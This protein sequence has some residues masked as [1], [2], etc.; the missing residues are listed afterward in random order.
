MHLQN[1]VVAPPAP[2]DLRNIHSWMA[3][4]FICSPV[5]TK[6]TGDGPRERPQIGATAGLG[7]LRAAL[8]FKEVLIANGTS[9]CT[10]LPALLSYMVLKKGIALLTTSLDDTACA[11]EKK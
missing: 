4:P 8:C 11:L 2:C 1:D 7:T 9:P 10:Y 3:D 5:V 6:A